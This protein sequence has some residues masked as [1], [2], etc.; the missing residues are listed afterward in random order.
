MKSTPPLRIL[1]AACGLFLALRAAAPGAELPSNVEWQPD[2]AVITTER[3]VLR[4]QV[5]AENIIRVARAGDRSFFGHPSLML[6]P[7]RSDAA[8][9]T[10]DADAAHASL[11]T[12][13][14]EARVGLPSGTVSFFDHA[15]RPILAEAPGGGTIEPARVGGIRTNHVAQVWLGSDGE[16]LYGMGEHHLGLVDIKGYDLDLWQHNGT[17]AIPFLMSSRG[18]GILWDNNSFTRFGD[19]RAPEDIPA[20]ELMDADGNPGGLLASYFAGSGFARRV[21]TRT[22]SAIDIRPAKGGPVSNA[23]IFPG[24]P[25]GE[26]SVR[27]EGFILPKQGGVHTL[28]AYSNGGI[29]VWVDGNLV[30]D[31]WRQGWLPWKDEAHVQFEAGRSYRVKVEW[32]REKTAPTIQLRWKTP[33][34]GADTSVWSEAGE[35]ID[36]YF[37]YGPALDDVVAGY[38]HLTGAAPMMPQWAF[39]L[40]QSRQRYNTAQDSIDVVKGFR[41]RMIPF[42][43]IVQDWFYWPR[44]G[45]GSHEF[46]PARFPDPAGW[47]RT[48]HDLNAHVM[49]SVW[50]KFYSGTRNFEAFRVRGFLFQPNLDEHLIDW[51]GLPYTF[52][53]AFLP[54]ARSLFWQQIDRELFSKQI[55]AWWLDASE[56]DL[57]SGPTLDGLR[58]HLISPAGGSEIR[59]MNAYP[60]VNSSA[61]YEGQ[62]AAAPGQ[63]VFILTRSGF[64]GQQRYAAAVWSGDITSTWTAMRKQIQAGLGF[65][66]S[67]MPYWTM[68]TGGFAVPARFST[69]TPTAADTAEWRELNARWFEFGAFVPLLRVHGE[70]PN[71]E[72]WEFGGDHS[73]TFAAELKFDRLRYRLLPYIYS[74]A[75][76]VTQR[77]GTFMR[78]LVMDFRDDAKAREIA[79]QYMFGPAILVSPVTSYQA[80]SRPVFLPATTGGWYDF[81]SGAPVAGGQTIEAPAP[82]DA[83]PLHVRAGSIIPVGPDQQYVGEKPADPVMLY[84]Y[85]G[86]D[87]A[88]SLYEDDGVSNDYEHGGFSRIPISW[89]DASGKLTIGTRV[90]SFAGMP[91]ARTFQLVLV[92][93]SK[94]AGFQQAPEPDKIVPYN[95]DPVTVQLR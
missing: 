5:C 18:Y 74:M 58:T 35:G 68:D 60:L 2:G 34:P 44:A 1:A 30:I 39:G 93:P 86:A 4:L 24:L 48:L 81:W 43:N 69:G 84:V 70:H 36:Y 71:R 11:R 91:A 27:W 25:P 75:G 82:F 83:I 72:M 54:D 19:L 85:S 65:S 13:S 3:G 51:V 88:F 21:A 9:W 47:I 45:W 37:V 95:G 59:D 92:A 32:V 31:H 15:G 90:G 67:G 6:D 26:L 94:A 52:Y 41:D 76:D 77:G 22:E 53:D 78:A 33:A 80:R 17:A 20:D 42:D 61:V 14:I 23:A 38:R 87:G 7:G 50:P 46:D 40:W 64:A 10:L 62:R 49:I 12:A 55:D 57:Q 66:L 79:D 29:K 73:P 63:R 56:P 89:D 28:F 16:S 8:L